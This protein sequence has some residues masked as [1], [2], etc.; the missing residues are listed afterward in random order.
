LLDRKVM[1]HERK[2]DDLY[3]LTLDANHRVYLATAVSMP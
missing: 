1:C 2:I 3:Q